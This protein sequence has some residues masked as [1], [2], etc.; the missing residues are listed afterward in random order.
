MN[1]ISI[2]VIA[3]LGLL[4]TGAI[5]VAQP[6]SKAGPCDGDASKLCASKGVP[7]AEVE[8]CLWANHNLLSPAC[9]AERDVMLKSAPCQV[10]RARFCRAMTLSDPKLHTCLLVYGNDS[11]M[12]DCK[13]RLTATATP[14]KK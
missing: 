1:R 11:L 14:A 3:F 6:A 2:S 10:D 9:K 8:A 4:L 5:A 13:K 7:Q 12:P